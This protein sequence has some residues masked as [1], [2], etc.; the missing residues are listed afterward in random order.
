MKS[1]V[2]QLEP[3]RVK[4]TVE[5]EY[6]ELKPAVDTAAKKLSEQ[7]SIPGFRRGKVPT[8]ILEGRIGRP[9]IIEQ[10]VNDSLDGY[11][12]DAIAENELS[13]IGQPDVEITEWPAMEGAPGGKL[14]V[15]ISVDTRPEI[16]LPNLSDITLTAEK[17]VVTDEDVEARM[18][19]MRERFATLKSVSRPVEPKDYVSID[20]EAKIGDEVVDSVS[21]I[22][23][24]LGSGNLL[25]G[26]DEALEG[27]QAG[28]TTTFTSTLAG[29]EHEGEEADVTVTV[30]SV[31]ESELPD[32]DD[33]FAQLASEF[34][35]ID[36]FTADLRTA[37][38]KDK[39]T[40]V[41]YG[42]R[43]LLLEELNK[44]LEVPVPS[45]VIDA[46][47]KRHLEAEGK[48]EGDPHGDEIREDTEKTFRDQMILDA[49]TE[50]LEVT[51]GQD[52]LL[53]F[54]VQQAQMYKIEP[55]QFIQAAAQTNQISAFA[56]ELTRNKALILALREVKVVDENGDPIDVKSI[57]DEN[58]GT[59]DE[60]VE[61][62]EAPVAES[63]DEAVTVDATDE[64]EAEKPAPKK[65]P[66]KKPAA[67]KAPA[68]K[69]DEVE[70]EE[71][72]APKKA[73]AKK[74]AAKKA[75]A[76]KADEVEGEEK[77][78]PKKAPAKKP[79]AK[80]APAKKAPAKKVE[81]A[82]DE[83]K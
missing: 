77:P 76:K 42:A 61:T 31:K 46:E 29:G 23:Y 66:A 82:E 43:D 63:A 39:L 54:M 28:E 35:T 5:V 56:G 71:K 1:N 34:D 6:D 70:G 4:I 48:E 13:P 52:E 37:A 57:I 41:V 75:P 67:K 8:R 25:E 19:E 51:I 68:K 33:D 24:Q 14:V 2:E 60:A 58:E 17:P 62:V 15:E 49:I 80:K 47:I 50:K 36:E 27:L 81:S 72:P 10:A 16:T 45:R 64:P 21:G 74:P 69:A 44:Q 79:A 9:A 65:A 53:E 20:M 83:T 11:Y 59:A 30:Q 38:E 3:T 22:S 73:P 40:D 12:Q 7:I 32:A 78:A 55:N 26:I 18:T